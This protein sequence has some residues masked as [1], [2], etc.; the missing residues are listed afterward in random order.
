MGKNAK[1]DNRKSNEAVLAN[2]WSAIQQGDETEEYARSGK[3]FRFMMTVRNPNIPGQV[4]RRLQAILD[5]GSSGHDMPDW[6][7][8]RIGCAEIENPLKHIHINTVL[9]KYF[10][11]TISIVPVFGE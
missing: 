8:K 2:F 10:C 3:L 6:L 5:T 9:G 1:T 7:T 4:R 11:N